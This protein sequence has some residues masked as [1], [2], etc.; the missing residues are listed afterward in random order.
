MPADL[1]PNIL[2]CG[3][4]IRWLLHQCH[5]LVTHVC[6]T[7]AQCSQLSAQLLEWNSNLVLQ[8]LLNASSKLDHKQ[9][10]LFLYLSIPFYQ[11]KMYMMKPLSV[12]WNFTYVTRCTC[13]TNSLQ[14][15]YKR[16]RKP[17][18]NSLQWFNIISLQDLQKK[19][20][21]HVVVFHYF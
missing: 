1:S 17:H 18:N 13:T 10:Y 8:E 3:D 6:T 2:C 7:P 11:Y 4:T 21:F 14:K 19:Q 12:K 16:T 15:K 5:N 9:L 20:V